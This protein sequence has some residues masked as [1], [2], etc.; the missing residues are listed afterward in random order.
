M[1]TSIFLM[2]SD[3]MLERMKKIKRIKTM[4]QIHFMKKCL[5][6]CVVPKRFHV[7]TGYKKCS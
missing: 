2:Y 3:V 1:I 5:K 7:I 6:M 4:D